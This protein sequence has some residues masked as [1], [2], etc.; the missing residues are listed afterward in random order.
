MFH[1]NQIKLRFLENT[2]L[3]N[4]ANK[5]DILISFLKT[6]NSIGLDG[7]EI[8]TISPCLARE[9]YAK[10]LDSFPKVDIVKYVVFERCRDA[11]VLG[12][13]KAL[14][15]YALEKKSKYVKTQVQS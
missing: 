14:D 10:L 5:R 7:Y 11:V 12:L 6:K 13:K 2:S 9:L 3:E 15:D 1:Q 4:I 8:T